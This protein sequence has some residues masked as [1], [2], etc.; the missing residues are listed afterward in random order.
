M[1]VVTAGQLKKLS[2]TVFEKM[3]APAE[4]AEIVSNYM[5][6]SHLYGHDTHGVISLPRFVDDIRIG[7]IDPSAEIEV[8]RSG[9]ATA[10]VDGKW[11]FG[12]VTATKAMEVAV[13]IAKQQGVSAVGVMNGNHIGMLWG[14]AK[15]AVDQGLIGIVFCSS[16]P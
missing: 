13:E 3:G 2:F 11:V 12:Y 14:Y 4:A 6:D 1:P 16:G 15:I 7:K 10:V 5:V 9:P 8:A